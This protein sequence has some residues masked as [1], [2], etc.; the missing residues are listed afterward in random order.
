MYGRKSLYKHEVRNAFKELGIRRS[1]QLK[2]LEVWAQID[3]D[4][5][6]SMDL[7]EFCTYFQFEPGT[8]IVQVL[9]VH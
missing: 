9:L 4:E 3:S 2:W 5:S 6:N 7:D 1:E 8:E